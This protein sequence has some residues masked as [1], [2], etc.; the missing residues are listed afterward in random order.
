MRADSYGMA[1]GGVL[2]NVLAA[3]W[4]EEDPGG[5]GTVWSR[6]EDSMLTRE[7]QVGLV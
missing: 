4:G 6:R 5:T 7:I 1:H 3:S 2:P